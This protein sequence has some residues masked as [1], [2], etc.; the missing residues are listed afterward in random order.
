MCVL[1]IE[2]GSFERAA[3]VLHGSIEPSLQLLLLILLTFF[4]IIYFM[5]RSTL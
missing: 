3:I 5:Y 2:P 4:L 1:G